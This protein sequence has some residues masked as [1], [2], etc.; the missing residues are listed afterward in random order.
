[1]AAKKYNRKELLKGPD[2][3]M[4][5]SARALNFLSVHTR[6][7]KIIGTVIGILVVLYL[8]GNTYLDYVNKKGYEA[9][10]KAYQAS[11]NTLKP[12]VKS[13]DL[14]KA[15]TLFAQVKDDHGLSKASRLALPQLAHIKFLEKKYDEAIA[16]YEKFLEKV[17]G[18]KAYA[19]LAHMALASCYEA[20][21]DVKAAMDLLNPVINAP[22][23]P[24]KEP[25]ML[26]LARLYKLD[27]K[28]EKAK[29]II[30]EFVETFKESPFLPVA[31]TYL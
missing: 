25:A 6:H 11:V 24:F 9:Y 12:D 7:L 27:Q 4:T 5:L 1:M 13:E 18:D 21:G 3:F 10:N 26:S 28:P 17:S 22:D 29:E 20:K 23:H 14:E 19:P 30:K 16:L 2:E 31:K 15:E 8:A